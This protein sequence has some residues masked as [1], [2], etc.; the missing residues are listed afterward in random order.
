MSEATKLTVKQLR[1]IEEFLLDGNVTAAAKRAGYSPKSARVTGQETLSNPAVR[2]A[3]QARQ[4]AEAER[5][6]IT[7]ENVVAGLLEAAEQAKLMSNP[8]AMVRAWAE[9]GRLFNF[10]GTQHHRVEVTAPPGDLEAAYARMSDADLMRLIGEGA[11][12]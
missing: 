7:R 8:M 9:L 4:A 5:M 3:L 6:G 1:F 12:G 10:Y 11:A 2:V